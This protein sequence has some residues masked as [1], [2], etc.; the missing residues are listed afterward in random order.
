MCDMHKPP[1]LLLSRTPPQPAENQFPAGTVRG[2]LS[3]RW[4]SGGR[5][6]DVQNAAQQSSHSET[7]DQLGGR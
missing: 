1:L 4:C 3:E 5:H 7:D 2:Q 6:L